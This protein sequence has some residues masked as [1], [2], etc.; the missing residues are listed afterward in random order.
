MTNQ[1]SSLTNYLQ[2]VLA[3]F[4]EARVAREFG[5][6]LVWADT[7][8]ILDSE[9]DRSDP[10]APVNLAL[11]QLVFDTVLNCENLVLKC[12]N[13]T[14]THGDWLSYGQ[15]AN[16]LLVA[17]LDEKSPAS[18]AE[19]DLAVVVQGHFNNLF[20][21]LDK[22]FDSEI[23]YTLTTG[24]EAKLLLDT[25]S[26]LRRLIS[27]QGSIKINKAVDLAARADL[28]RIC[29]ESPS[30]LVAGF[31]LRF[32]SSWDKA[33]FFIE[34]A[35]AIVAEIKVDPAFPDQFVRDRD[36]LLPGLDLALANAF[37]LTS[38]KSKLA[39]GS[40]RSMSDLGKR[41]AA[42]CSR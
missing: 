16:D 13:V 6:A 31:P 2:D 35:Q 36:V 20:E 23:M 10:T 7:A 33:L 39:K 26:L 5:E 21:H 12:G 37:A 1:P 41:L 8:A 30:Y 32:L 4:N 24:E 34:G 42:A 25:T 22:H 40:Y 19:R 11:F 38:E 29:V 27:A 15:A 28:L 18:S 17:R 14:T 9:D 3:R